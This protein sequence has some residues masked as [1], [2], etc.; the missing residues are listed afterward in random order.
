MRIQ[1]MFHD[2][3]NRPI[4]GVIKVD[5]DAVEVIE[6]EVREYVITKELRKHFSAFF[7]YYSDSFDVPTADIG[8][9]ISGFFGSGKSHFLKML[10]YILENRSIGSTN[11]VEMFRQKFEDDP[12][13][14]MQIDRATK[15]ETE[16]I[17]FNIDIESSINKDKTAVMRVFAKMFYNHLGFYGENLKVAMLEYYIEQ[18][19]KTEEFRRVFEEKKG[20]SWVEMRRAFAFNGKFIIPTLMEVL[21][22]SEE[23]A[24]RWFDDKSATELSIA[25]LVRDIKEYVDSKPK[26]FRLLFMIDEVGQYVGTDTD[27]LLNL[28]SLAEKIGSECEGKV[29]V[30]CTGQEAIDEII[31]VRADEFSRIQARFKTR[32][33]LSSS[34]V[35]EVIQKRILKKNTEAEKELAEVY[36]QN[37]SVLRNLFTFSDAQLDIKGYGTAFEFTTNFPFVPYQFIIMQ[38]VFAEIRKHGNSGK[39]LSGGERSMLSGFQ[40]AAQKVQDKDEYTLVPFFRFY[41][42]VHSFLDGSIRRVIERCA[43]AA[44]AGDGIDAYDVDVLKLLYLIRYIDNDVPANLDNIVILMADDIRVDKITLR[45]E[46]RDSL[47]RLLSQNYIGRTG[48][49]YN[50]LTDEE[51]DIQRAIKN[52]TSVDTAAIVERIAQMIFADIYTTKK[53][54]YG[55]YDFAFDQMV[56]GVSVGAITGGMRLRFL[57][58]ATD[59]TDK[60]KLRLMTESHGQAIVVLAETD[61]YNALEQAMKIRKY[62]KQRNVAQLPKSVQD[63]IRDQQDEATRLEVSASEELKKAIVSAEFYVAGENIEVKAGD[64]KSKIDQALEY[65]VAHVYSEL[66]LITQHAETDADIL[67]ILLGTEAMVPGTEPNRDAA[68]KMEE[69]LE[70][71]F[72]KNLPTSMADVQSRY[73][74]IPYGWRE[75]DIAAVAARLIFEQKVTIKYAGTT[76]QP[77]NPKLPDMLRKKSEIGKTAIS[78][79]QIVSVTKMKEAKEFLREYF[80]VMD[81]PNDEDGLIAFIVEKFTKQKEHYAALDARYEGHKYPDRALVQK[82]ISLM[83]AVL[84]QQKDNIALID[85]VVKKQDEIFNNKDQ[86]QRVESFFKNQVAIFDEAV[87]LEASLRH[88]LDYLSHEPEANAALNKIRAICIVQSGDKFDYKRIPEL[89]DLMKEVHA[90]HDR[91]LAAKREEL[92]E[93]V[94]Q[95]LEAIHTAGADKYDAKNIMSTADNFYVQKKQQIAEYQSLALLDGLLPPMLQYKDTTVEKIEARPD[96]AKVDIQPS[97]V[98]ERKEPYEA[99]QPATPKK[100][101]KSLNRSIV[102]PAKRLESEADIDNYVEKMRESLKQ[103]L[104]NCDGIQLK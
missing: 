6:Q 75:I 14:F 81:V 21:D 93:I 45:E 38:K 80:D 100:I 95:C 59:A 2:D 76:I 65:L 64:A 56:D 86:M 36:D 20:K 98:N 9:W 10:S 39:H 46:V 12:A 40:E 26:N 23:D 31:K 87:Q 77:N 50:F 54:R 11:T 25:Q 72:R 73:Q 30:C 94:R 74:A 13:T 82:A 79:R 92:L 55:K 53:Y 85:C 71:Q 5:Q 19:G 66:D 102:F 104:K 61:Y 8:V 44:E 78:K 68:A 49:T 43:R 69:Y 32:L 37:D 42:T 41:D 15:G 51:Q 84:S 48:E 57:T 29:W 60:S 101:Y 7:N 22:M 18:S 90:G 17:L 103:L 63:I 89:N 47:N 99:Q 83:E 70:V 88:E 28:Q 34:S 67:S 58:V 27:M 96:P 35:D 24:K 16:T 91:L 62:V 97:T 33:S 4:N 52:E 1:S 3:I